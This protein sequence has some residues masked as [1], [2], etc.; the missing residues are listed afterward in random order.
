MPS[1]GEPDYGLQRNN[2]LKMTFSLR[3]L[4]VTC[5]ETKWL[6][7]ESCT[8]KFVYRQK[9]ACYILQKSSEWGVRNNFVCFSE[10]TVQ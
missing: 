1:W 6:I 2:F 8:N 5:I 9:K 7:H 4:L 10:V 3:Y